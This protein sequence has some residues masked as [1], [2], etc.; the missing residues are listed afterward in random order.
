MVKVEIPL[1]HIQQWNYV[2]YTL[3]HRM[4]PWVSPI[5]QATHNAAV[6]MHASTRHKVAWVLYM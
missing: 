1:L 4:K 3:P 6:Y 2:L 5:N